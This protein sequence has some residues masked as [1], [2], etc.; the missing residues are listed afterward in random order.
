MAVR[1]THATKSRGFTLTEVL[2]TFTVLGFVS[3]GLAAFLVEA[4]RG[5]FWSAQK[6]L[7]TRDVRN[8]TT[9]ISLET[10]GANTGYVYEGFAR[11]DRESVEDQRQSGQTGDCLVLI[12]LDPHPDPDDDKHY[13]RLVVYFRQPDAEG[14]SPVYR[15][16]KT[17]NTPLA[18][19]TTSRDHFENLLRAH[20]PD[21][22]TGYPVVLELSRG[23]ANGSLFL[24]YGNNTFL[25]NGEILHGNTV[26]EV[27][28]TYNLTISPRG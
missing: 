26:K 23:L 1:P 20:F 4:N 10:L 7:I 22:P 25:V 12:Y 16:E 19:D 5:M 14:L 24:N 13:T 15:A 28:N 6:S 17:F 11:A 3:V 18:I 2:I 9:R 27:T 21:D 8:F